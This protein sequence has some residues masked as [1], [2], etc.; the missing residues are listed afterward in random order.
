M[1]IYVHIH[2]YIIYIYMC[3]CLCRGMRFHKSTVIHNT[4]TR[5]L[6]PSSNDST[7]AASPSRTCARPGCEEAPG[8]EAEMRYNTWMDGLMDDIYI[9]I[10]IFIYSICKY[11]YMYVCSRYVHIYKDMCK[12]IYIYIRM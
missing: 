7:R 4:L 11:V 9:Y 5:L 12:Y 2:I 8:G 10:H 3:V 6:S 1:Y